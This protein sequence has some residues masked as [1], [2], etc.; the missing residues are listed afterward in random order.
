MLRTVEAFAAGMVR[1]APS[2]H[3]HSGTCQTAEPHG[4]EILHGMVWTGVGI[5]VGPGLCPV[6]LKSV[7]PAA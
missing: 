5:S 3:S 1:I 2:C 7:R 6:L 4:P